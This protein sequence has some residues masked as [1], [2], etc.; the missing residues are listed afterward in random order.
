[1]TSADKQRIFRA[2]HAPPEGPPYIGIW[3]REGDAHCLAAGQVTDSL[4]QLALEAIEEFW[5]DQ[6][7]VRKRAI[8]VSDS[9]P[10]RV[11]KR[12]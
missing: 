12:A 4:K 7:V 8:K 5:S 6:P 2:K 10:A 1:M 9:A 11:R 3:L